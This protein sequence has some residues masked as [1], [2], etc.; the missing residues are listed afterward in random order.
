MQ[1]VRITSTE[2]DF[3]QEKGSETE[4]FYILAELFGSGQEVFTRIYSQLMQEFLKAL[5]L[6]LHFHYSTI[7]QI[8][9]LPD[10]IHDI[11][12]YVVDTILYSK[13]IDLWQ[14]LELAFEL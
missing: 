8:N 9:D 14:Q 1:S 2:V 4:L 7:H 6:V 10:V 13:T 12:I 3:L 11:V 5:F